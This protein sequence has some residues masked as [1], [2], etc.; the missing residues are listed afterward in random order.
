[1]TP[2]PLPNQWIVL[3]GETGTNAYTQLSSR[4]TD[5]LIKIVNKEGRERIIKP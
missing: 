1:M 5:P 2:R 4:G 3:G